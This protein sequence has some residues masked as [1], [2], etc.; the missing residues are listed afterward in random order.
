MIAE[1]ARF[2]RANPGA[3]GREI[4]RQLGLDKGVVNSLLSTRTPRHLLMMMSS[5]GH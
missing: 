4:A 3:K 2:L 5:A 1:I